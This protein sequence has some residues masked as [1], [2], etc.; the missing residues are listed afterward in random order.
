MLKTIDVLIGV[1]TILLLFSMAVTTITQALTTATGRRGRHLRTGLAT[2]LQQLGI[3]SEDIAR[4]IADSLL[5][6]PL[7]AETKG[8]LGTVIHRE[9][10]TKL[11]LDLAS[12]TGAQKLEDGRREALKKA[13]E[14]GGIPDP[15]QTLK[16]VR[17]MALHLE[18]SN[19]ELS[20]D[21]RDALA[22]LHEAPSDFVARVNSW[23][24]QT[25]DRVS[26]RFTHY[27]HW[28]TMGAAVLVV[29]VAQLD[30][31]AIADRLWI[32][33]QF[34]DKVV[35]QATTQF[36]DKT[37]QASPAN[38]TL[39]VNPKPY[40]DLLNSTALITLPLDR[41]YLQQLKDSRKIPGMILSVLLISLGAPFWYNALKDLLKLRSS[42]SQADD[43]QRARRQAAPDAGGT[44]P[45]AGNAGPQP[46]WLS[47][48]RGDLTAVG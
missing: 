15:E 24:D 47:G 43:A 10:F 18:A 33:D 36:S 25:I 12:G 21:A 45:P 20:N 6:H 17:A 29:L 27:T 8:K 42:L 40:Y 46:S 34:R 4:K 2:L 9:E 5:R 30:I 22:I 44:A 14:E 48:E 38:G 23:F 32:D 26:Q 19:P 11:L 41:D 28:I 7:I 3:A 35:S 1:T 31:I 16:N 13:L 37:K 39:N